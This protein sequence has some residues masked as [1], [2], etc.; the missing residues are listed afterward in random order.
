MGKMNQEEM[1][2]VEGVVRSMRALRNDRRFAAARQCFEEALRG[3]TAVSPTARER[4]SVEAAGVTYLDPELPI[5]TRLK[6]AQ[7]LVSPYVESSVDPETLG[8]AG[9]I[10]RRFYDVDTRVEHL[11]RALALYSK[12]HELDVAHGWPS[13]GYTGINAAHL[14]DMIASIE[15]ASFLPIPMATARDRRQRARTIREQLMGC[16]EPPSGNAEHGYWYRVTLAEAALGLGDFDRAKQEIERALTFAPTE[17]MLHRTATQIAAKLRQEQTDGQI[18]ENGREVLRALVP[19]GADAIATAIRGRLGLALSGGGFRASFFHIG[20]LARLSEVDLLRHVE[21][22]SCVSGG[23]LLGA[24]YALE[25]KQLQEAKADQA[26]ERVDYVEIVKRMAR[27]F[28]EEVQ[29]NIRV[30]VAFSVVENW[31]M[32]SGTKSR[33]HRA[34]ELYEQ[35]L[36]ARVGEVETRYETPRFMSD[37]VTTPFGV[38]PFSRDKDNWKRKSKVPRVVF[39][40]A[41]L[42]TGHAWHFTPE[43][44]GEP[45]ARD[46]DVDVNDRF[47]TLPYAMFTKVPFMPFE[48]PL[49]HAVAAS[50]CVPGLF[51]PLPVNNAYPSQRPLLVDGGVHDN[52]GTAALLEQDCNALI[53]S[54]ASGQLETDDDP[55]NSALSSLIR[56]DSVFQARIR[57]AQYQDLMARE[58]GRL[59][60][61]LSFLHLKQAFTRRELRPNDAETTAP[62]L[63]LPYPISREVQQRLAALRTDLD[64][65]SSLEMEALMASGYLIAAHAIDP[66]RYEA[67]A[68]PADRF[69][70]KPVQDWFEFLRVRPLLTAVPGRTQTETRV[71]ELLGAGKMVAGKIF[72]ISRSAR[73]TAIVVLAIVGIGAVTLTWIFRERLVT[74]L[75]IGVAAVMLGA[76]VLRKT[77]PETGALLEALN[78]AKSVTAALRKAALSVFASLV[79]RAHVRWADRGFL[80]AGDVGTLL[81][82][83]AS[84]RQRA[85]APDIRK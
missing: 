5:R 67:P 85:G 12:G 72:A 11:E 33:S 8:V 54:D 58:Q 57:E 31:A 60:S 25:L 65:F 48:I 78:P 7:A 77:L 45:P 27:R 34:A 55:S 6:R 82:S 83:L 69:S 22:L 79:A 56:S 26:I 24:L 19:D 73:R 46:E 75:T 3:R 66:T 71:L 44:M 14:N 62:E 36:Y 41:T 80:A 51:E 16:P 52:Q 61:A 43:G 28:S 76:F 13:A 39:N 40:A 20:V 10:E 42:N 29:K 23:S 1:T 21:V 63:P 49:G 15:E 37:L 74:H 47:V 68:P 18:S 17:L 59:V 32:V 81:Q 64:A 38:G 4:L 30:R 84:D 70:E 35:Y 50:A 9:A 2:W 53:V